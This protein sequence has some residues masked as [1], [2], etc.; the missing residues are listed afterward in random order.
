M[1]IP[2]MVQI[3][4]LREEVGRAHAEVAAKTTEGESLRI[5]VAGMFLTLSISINQS[6]MNVHDGVK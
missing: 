3:N 4:K 5:M 6:I 1:Y 2:V